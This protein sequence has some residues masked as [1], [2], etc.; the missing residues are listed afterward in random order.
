[1][2]TWHEYYKDQNKVEILIKYSIKLPS[3]VDNFNIDDHPLH[4]R[5]TDGLIY[6]NYHKK[7]T[8]LKRDDRK[9]RLSSFAKGIV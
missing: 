8:Q 3:R 7:I 4:V 2:K 1:M 6:V 5:Q 9:V